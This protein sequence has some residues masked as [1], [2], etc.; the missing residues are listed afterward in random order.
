MPELRI[1]YDYH[2]AEVVRLT[3]RGGRPRGYRAACRACGW[4]GADRM[5]KAAAEDDATAHD[6][7]ENE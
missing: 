5:T 6:T 1:G 3:D 2:L 4:F 7:A